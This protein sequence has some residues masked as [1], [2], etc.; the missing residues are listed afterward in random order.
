MKNFSPRRV[1][2]GLAFLGSLAGQLVNAA[3]VGVRIGDYFFTPTNLVINGGD[4]VS[5]TNK[6]VFSHDT[7]HR[8]V[9]N[10]LWASTLLSFNGSFS[11]TLSNAG[12]YPYMCNQHVVL[13]PVFHPE[14]T[15]SISVV[16]FKITSPPD[17]AQIFAGSSLDIQA[18]ASSNVVRASYFAGA[19]LLGVVTNSPFDFSAKNLAA[20][21]Y[22]LSAAITDNLGR[23]LTNAGPK[24]TIVAPTIDT[25]HFLSDGRFQFNIR[26]GNPGETCVIFASPDL[27]P[28]SWSPI[29]TNTFPA[30]ACLACTSIITF[31]D[32][33]SPG[34]SHRFYKAEAFP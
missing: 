5:W 24:I 28:G 31:T 33:H 8:P 4:K 19:N 23:T 27:S 25:L 2:L 7:T 17:G 13:G 15:G 22:V 3:T 21:T 30:P 11:F 14:Q 34:L 32:D 20:G 1:L 10:R 29:G 18:T 12:Y 6:G 16:S 9:T 26:D